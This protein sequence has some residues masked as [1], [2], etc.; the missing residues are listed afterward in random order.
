MQDY[1]E[2]PKLRDSISFL[3]VERA[4][5]S[6]K[7]SAIEI[8][9]DEGVMLAPAANLGVLMLGPGT[10]ISH[11]AVKALAQFG[12]SIIWTGEELARFYA[13]GLGETRK[14]YHLLHQAQM[15]C[16]P[17]THEQV[18]LRMYQKRFGVELDA[19]LTLPQVRG[20]EGVRVRT[21][22]AEASRQY[23]VE[24]HGR[25]YDRHHW[26]F[27][28]PLNRA[29][30]TANALL[31][32]LCHVAIISGGYSPA[33][34]FIH[35]GKQLSFVYDIA[36]LYKVE[37][38]IP[39]AFQAVA[40]GTEGLEKRVRR[41]CREQFHQVRL[42]GRILPDIDELLRTPEEPAAVETTDL[43]ALLLADLW[44]PLAAEPEA[45]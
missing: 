30:S 17:T 7:D 20:L 29:L 19:G 41:A 36:D 42:L 18:V 16:D 28:D 33:I 25:H 37:L 9:N 8:L 26:D 31:N 4:I 13:H 3:Y 5:V 40:E 12:C 43:E 10:T 45:D 27:S 23:G 11:A 2:L 1:H 24:W 14:A 15:A 35:V 6:V 21:A 22:Y 44:Q 38:T 39:V 34:G 32:S